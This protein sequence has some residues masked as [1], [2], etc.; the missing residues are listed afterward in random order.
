MLR[1][2][3]KLG[4]SGVHGVGL[5]ADQFV[6]KGTVTWQYDPKFDIGYTEKDLAKMSSHGQRQILWYAYYDKK[7]KKLILPSDDQRF[8]NHSFKHRN[9][10]STPQRDIAMRDIQLGEELFCNYNEFD[11]TYF[12]RLGYTKSALREPK[13]TSQKRSR[14]GKTSRRTIKKKTAPLM[15]SM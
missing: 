11:N 10:K 9:I 4:P 1:I 15:R 13:K 3:A 5:F 14:V 2:K 12:K 7:L 6:P 8:I